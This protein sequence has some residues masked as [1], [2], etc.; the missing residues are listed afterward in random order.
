MIKLYPR[1]DSLTF[2][3]IL[4]EA[5]Q[6]NTK[7]AGHITD[8]V[9]IE[10]IFS[11]TIHSIE[12][13]DVYRRKEN[14][15]QRINEFVELTN[16][17]NIWNC[18]TLKVFE[19]IDTTQHTIKE[20]LVLPEYKY[21]SQERRKNWFKFER[22]PYLTSEECKNTHSYMMQLFTKLVETNER[23]II[24]TDSGALPNMLAGFTFHDEIQL[25]RKCGIPNSKIL[26]FATSNAAKALDQFEDF[27]SITEGKRADLLLLANN[28]LEDINH[29]KNLEGLMVNGI[30]ITS[31]ELDDL[32][33]QLEELHKD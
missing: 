8:D 3:S 16:K 4:D 10:N 29:L 28:P 1:I 9:S 12:H 33:K 2:F 23:I 27:G 30:W 11:S 5:Q 22:G 7:V 31:S 15:E 24:G 32:H 20:K 17:S 26:K 6:R 25:Y 21:L 18:P 13:L 14:R 19:F